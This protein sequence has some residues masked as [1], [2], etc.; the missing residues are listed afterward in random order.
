MFW[1]YKVEIVSRVVILRNLT[2]PATLEKSNWQVECRRAILTL[3]VTI[4]KKL[5]NLRRHPRVLQNVYDRPIDFSFAAP[6]PL[7][8]WAAGISNHR[9]DEPVFNSLAIVFIARKPRDC[10][11]CTWGK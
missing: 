11:D 8:S 4:W 10:A 5:K 2:E 7:V 3:V 6:T 1:V 9:N